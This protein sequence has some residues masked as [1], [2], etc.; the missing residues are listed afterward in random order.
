[1]AQQAMRV[2][3]SYPF[4]LA[5]KCHR[6]M[7]GTQGG[8]CT[9]TELVFQLGS[10]ILGNPLIKGLLAKLSH[11]APKEFIIF[12]IL[13]RGQI[14]PQTQKE[15]VAL[16]SGWFLGKYPWKDSPAEELS[17]M[18]RN[19]MEN[20]PPTKNPREEIKSCVHLGPSTVLYPRRWLVLLALLKLSSHPETGVKVTH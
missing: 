11:F 16:T 5:P 20:S 18:Y 13:V 4:P 3:S 9:H 12:I 7:W 6:N 14:C 2:S 17:Q 10:L 1:M 19:S 15:I 8:C